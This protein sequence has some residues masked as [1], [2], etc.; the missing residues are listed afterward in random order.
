MT[1]RSC[2]HTPFCNDPGHAAHGAGVLGKLLIGCDQQQTIGLGLGQ[3]QAIKDHDAAP[4]IDPRP[5]MGDQV[6]DA[7]G[8]PSLALLVNLR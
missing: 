1:P 4:A 3:Q 8:L 7:D 5:A 6:Q 2:Q